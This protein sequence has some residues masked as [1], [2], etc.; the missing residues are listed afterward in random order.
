LPQAALWNPPNKSTGG[1]IQAENKRYLG[2]IIEDQNPATNGWENRRF[3][4]YEQQS[5]LLTPGRRHRAF[6]VLNIEQTTKSSRDRV[7]EVT[8]KLPRTIVPK[9]ETGSHIFAG[10]TTPMFGTTY[11][12]SATASKNLSITK[13]NPRRISKSVE[14]GIAQ[15]IQGSNAAYTDTSVIVRYIGTSKLIDT[16]LTTEASGVYAPGDAAFTA[17]VSITRAYGGSI[18]G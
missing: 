13:T 12:G 6:T 18:G 7:R 11:P 9:T 2:L 4:P 16:A 8:Y 3:I 5:A 15:S 14:E 1:N 10:G 17:S